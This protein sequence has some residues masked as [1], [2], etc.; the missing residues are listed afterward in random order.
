[1]QDLASYRVIT[2]I[3]DE[4][5]PS[6]QYF[7]NPIVYVY[8]TQFRAALKDIY[9]RK[10]RGLPRI[11]EDDHHHP[12]VEESSMAGPLSNTRR[13]IL[14]YVNRRQELENST[15]V[16]TA[17]IPIKITTAS[18]SE[19]GST[20]LPAKIP[21]EI[22]LVSPKQSQVIEHIFDNASYSPNE[23]T[24]SPTKKTVLSSENKQTSL[25]EQNETDNKQCSEFDASISKVNKKKKL[26]FQDGQQPTYQLPPIKLQGWTVQSLVL[27]DLDN[28]K[29]TPVAPIEEVSS[30]KSKHTSSNEQ[31]NI[32]AGKQY[33]EID[34]VLSRSNKKKRLSFQDGQ[35]STYELPPLK[36]HGRK[37]RRKSVPNLYPM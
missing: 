4:C 5:L 16:E 29:A 10:I 22:S 1:M 12:N 25:N 13:S 24:V 17:V 26:S 19:E 37:G 35:Q 20:S 21:S 6:M 34:A 30:G 2:I 31:N 18:S 32:H 3:V 11:T 28:L 27:E 23:Q 9:R 36:F 7:L 33:R 14:D 15:T 8:N